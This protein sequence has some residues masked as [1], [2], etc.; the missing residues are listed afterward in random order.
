VPDSLAGSAVK[1]PRCGAEFTAPGTAV[2][3][4]PAA[5][6]LDQQI[7]QSP[8]VPQLP[9]SLSPPVY[10]RASPGASREER[11][12]A[13]P[14]YLDEL[15]GKL[16]ATFAIALLGAVIV[17]EFIGIGT[18]AMEY[19]LYAKGILATDAEADTVAM[20]AGC[21]GLLQLAVR[22]GTAV[23]FCMWMYKAHENLRRLEATHLEYSPAWA[24]GGFFVPILN[25]WRPYQVAQEIYKASDPNVWG[26][27]D[28][29]DVPLDASSRWR[30]SSGSAI[31]GL[32][33]ALWLID[34]IVSYITLRMTLRGDADHQQLQ[35][36]AMLE[37]ISGVLSIA[38]AALAILLIKVI[39]ERQAAKYQRILRWRERS[40]RRGSFDN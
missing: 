5:P 36:A 23:A 12:C 31:I 9:P 32:W 26:G 11:G 13:L 2:A 35:L 34:G 37:I 1:C 21:A 40:D 25:L 17:T 27:V 16:R 14:E 24:A 19:N 38:A 22:I 8:Q 4:Y 15:P 39:Q 3:A 7:Q 20:L 30:A 33:W 29:L 28:E 10:G 18:S 6:P